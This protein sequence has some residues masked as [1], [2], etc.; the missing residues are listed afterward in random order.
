MW[1][2]ENDTKTISVDANCFENGAKQY[3]FNL[4]TMYC[5]RGLIHTSWLQ[6]LNFEFGAL[7][8]EKK[9]GFGLLYHSFLFKIIKGSWM[10]A[11]LGFHRTCA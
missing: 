10:T 5:G 1:T 8:K 6:N 9:E 11:N 4:K 7:R 3:R 2:G